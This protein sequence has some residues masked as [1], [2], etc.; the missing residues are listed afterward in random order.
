MVL[1]IQ[2]LRSGTANKRPQASS[3][4][5]GQ[6]AINYNEGDPGIYI[7]GNSGALIKV[8]PTYVGTTAPNASPASGG[9]AGNAKGE[10]WLDTST[11][12]ASLKIFD[13]SNFVSSYAFSDI[14]LAGTYAQSVVA[15]GNGTAIDC[16][17]GNYFTKTINGATT[18][19]FTNV[20]TSRAFS[21]VV[22]ITHTSGSVAWPSAVKFSA[23]G[24]PTLT[25][26]KTHLFM[27]VTDDGGSR[28][29]AAA[30]SDFD[31]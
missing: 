17:A 12:P 6:I 22:E 28:W 26:G 10:T 5:D 21:I 29:R 1:P 15:L 27:L 3:L 9:T 18:F 23:A 2:N 31:N 25:A 7:K 11:T 20:P 16:S 19:S 30:L 14:D 8:S 4:S 13:G 24:A